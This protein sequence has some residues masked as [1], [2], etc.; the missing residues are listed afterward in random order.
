MIR[1]PSSHTAIPFPLSHTPSLPPLPPPPPFLS[2]LQA[3]RFFNHVN[4]LIAIPPFPRDPLSTLTPSYVARL[5]AYADSFFIVGIRC[6]YLAIPAACWLLGPA[7]CLL[8]TLV[9]L[10]VVYQ[11]DFSADFLVQVGGGSRQGE[12]E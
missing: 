12:V 3:I 2:A 8:A 7:P 9:C 10:L 1:L 5:L 6:S 11:G 4:F